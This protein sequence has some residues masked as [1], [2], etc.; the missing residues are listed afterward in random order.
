MSPYWSVCMTKPQRE[1]TAVENLNRQN[2]I[3]YL[4][5]YLSKVGKVQKIKVLFPRYVFVYIESQWHSINNTFGVLSLVMNENKPAVVPTHIIEAL[6]SSE[7]KGLIELSVSSKFKQGEKVLLAE[8]P[9]SGY[10][11]IYDG[12]RDSERALVL[13][14]LLGRKVTVEV[15]ETNLIS[16]SIGKEDG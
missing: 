5:K 4:P 9:L 14:E 16:G 11:G 15:N 6:K 3:T 8:G 12:M 7:V 1:R 13:I 2:Y 10:I